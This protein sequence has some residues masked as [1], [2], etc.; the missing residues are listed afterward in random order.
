MDFKSNVS[1]LLTSNLKVD[2]KLAFNNYL[3]NFGLI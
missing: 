3:K 1:A 2:D